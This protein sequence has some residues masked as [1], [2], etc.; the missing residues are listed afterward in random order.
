MNVKF[1]FL[2]NVDVGVRW[3]GCMGCVCLIL[4]E[5]AKN[6]AIL[7][8]Q[9]ENSSCCTYSLNV[10]SVSVWFGLVF[11]HSNTV[12]SNCGLNLHFPDD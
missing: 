12:M 1:S 3:L 5:T 10:S 11:C 6:C 9:C 2:L 8:Q 7:H 4:Q